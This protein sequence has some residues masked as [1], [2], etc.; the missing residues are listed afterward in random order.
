MG[1]IRIMTNIILYITV[2][3]VLATNWTGWH[4][5]GREAG[6]VFTN[7]VVLVGYQ[8]NTN[9]MVVLSTPSDWAVWRKSPVSKH[10]YYYATNL[11]FTNRW[12]PG[13]STT[14]TTDRLGITNLMWD[15]KNAKP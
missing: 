3:L 12:T 7:S 9:S 8:G 4:H 2:S 5:D 1:S 13:I 10:Y 14:N 11:C 6:I 15:T